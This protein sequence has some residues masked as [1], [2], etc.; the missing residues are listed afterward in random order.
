M[1]NLAHSLHGNN[2]TYITQFLTSDVFLFK[3]AFISA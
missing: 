2:A 3:I 1:I